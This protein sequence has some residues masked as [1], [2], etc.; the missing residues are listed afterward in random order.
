MESQ[1][2]VEV[3]SMNFKRD[4]RTKQKERTVE[5]KLFLKSS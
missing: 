1:I 3:I 4:V 5:K 2:K